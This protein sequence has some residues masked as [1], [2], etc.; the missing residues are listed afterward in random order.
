[1]FRFACRAF[2]AFMS[3]PEGAARGANNEQPSA[4]P[5]GEDFT[6]K[7]DRNY[8][9]MAAIMYSESYFLETGQKWHPDGIAFWNDNCV[10]ISS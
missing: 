1:M 9:T 5:N 10:V 2:M 6:G 3:D 8:L 4:F 7:Y